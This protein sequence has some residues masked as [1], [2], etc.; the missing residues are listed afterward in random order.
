[1]SDFPIRCVQLS[2]WYGEVQGLSGLTVDIPSGV[3]GLLGPNGSGKTTL[4]RLL[5]GLIRPTRGH[6]EILGTRIGSDTWQAFEKIGYSPGDDIH[7]ETERGVDF[8]VM[9][10]RICGDGPAEAKRRAEGALDKVGMSDRAGVK[11]SAMS[12]GMRQRIKVAQALLF[13]PQVLLLDEPLNGMDPLSRRRTMDIVR[14]HGDAGGTVLLASHVLHEVE[15]ITD[16]VILLHHGR[17]LAEGRLAEIRD[18]I[19]MKPRQVT[20]TSPAVKSIAASLL[21]DNLVS[22]VAFGADG[23]LTLETRNLSTLI[24]R[25]QLLGEEGSIE[26]LD[27]ADEKLEEVFA[28]LVKGA[29]L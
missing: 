13:Q 3:V 20:L 28:L 5:T 1:M 11:L 18:L 27:I 2:R 9:M 4:L 17:L 15:N 29:A 12:K 22:G 24:E 25:L 26:N 8:L 23:H 21:A 10:A 16:K 14:E 7:F 19:E 6:A